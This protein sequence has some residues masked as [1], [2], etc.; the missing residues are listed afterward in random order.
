MLSVKHISKRYGAQPVLRG[1][2]LAVAAGEF[3]SLLGPS[4]CGKTTLLRILCGIETPDTGSILLQGQDITRQPASQRRFGVVFQSY[5]LF[6]NLTV[7]QN[8]SYGLQDLGRR[9]RAARALE[10]LALVGLAEQAHKYPA[11]LSGG[12]Q[13]RVALARALAPRPRLLLLDEPLSALDAQVRAGLRSEIRRLQKQLGITTLMV[14]HDQDEALSMSD[15][16]VLMH[17]GQVEQQGSPQ[18]LYAR[19][20]SPF[21]AGFVGKMNL[22]PALVVA[23]GRARVGAQELACDTHGFK[24]GSPVLLGLRPEAIALRP[25]PST[26]PA[27]AQ[28]NCLPAEVLDTVFLGPCTLVRL[29]CEALGAEHVLEAELPT[30]RDAQLPAWLQGGAG[31]PAQV[32][33]EIPREALHALAQPLSMRAEPATVFSQAVPA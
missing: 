8:V 13:Q 2:E 26:F 15:R 6:P 4:G 3:I 17:Q 11:Q 14:T 29:R 20:A 25:L 31:R 5:A 27:Q 30:A 21:A 7:A 24:T 12:Q 9:E 32:L 10:M 19:P 18:A 1:I 16:V 23:G 22:L 33:L 28:P